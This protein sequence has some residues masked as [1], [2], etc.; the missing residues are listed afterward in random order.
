MPPSSPLATIAGRRPLAALLGLPFALLLAVG[1]VTVVAAA[2]A[3]AASSVTI[4]GL[5]YTY[6][7]DEPAAGATLTSCGQAPTPDLVIPADITVA[8]IDF[9]VV[10]TGETACSAR[11]LTSV[12]LP[13]SLVTVGDGSFAW[14]ELASV[15]L[16]NSVTGL[17]RYAFAHNDM[18]SVIMSDSLA[19]I[20]GSAFQEN[21]LTTVTLPDSLISIYEA[22]FYGNRLTSL[23][24]PD[25]VTY[26]GNIAF[27][28]NR[29]TSLTLSSN[30]TTMHG[31][32]FASN[33]LTSVTLPDS[34]TALDYFTFADNLLETVT[35]PDTLTSVE[36]GAF[37]GNNLTSVTLP[38]SLTTLSDQ[39]FNENPLLTQVRFTGPAPTTIT[40]ADQPGPSLGTAPGL[41][42]AFHARHLAKTPQEGFTTPEWLGYST[43][44]A[45]TVT[46]ETGG[47]SPVSPQTVWPGETLQ[48]PPAPVRPGY[49]FIGWSSTRSHYIPFLPQRRLTR[50]VT[51]YAGWRPVSDPASGSLGSGGSGSGSSGSGGSGSG[52][53]GSGG[54]GSGG[55]SSGSLGS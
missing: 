52:S 43:V 13:D 6:N 36:R 10:A 40:A 50:D 23:E 28:E 20:G 37:E 22:A 5:T 26:I 35:L 54:S 44:P 33:Q 11:G 16:P 9:P 3:R 49:E 53:L 31:F 47:G 25:S 21:L 14:N 24:V 55:S 30:L 39:V 29:L 32:A 46:F 8:G 48:M 4:D 15:T 34:L 42:V 27:F 2:P 12:D 41:T 18:T 38:S 7:A 17:G 19:T 51:A 45:H 1:M